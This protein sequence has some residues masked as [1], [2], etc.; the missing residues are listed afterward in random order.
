MQRLG[1]FDLVRRARWLVLRDL[2]CPG[3]LIEL[4]FVSHP[5]KA[6][7]VSTAVFRQTLA[8]SLFDGIVQYGK[9]LQ[10]IP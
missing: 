2:D 5:E 1:G 4:G 9:C 6:Q 10:R 8:Y 3:V 7:K